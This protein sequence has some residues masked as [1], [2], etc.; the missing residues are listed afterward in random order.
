M[1]AYVSQRVDGPLFAVAIADA[2]SPEVAAAWVNEAARGG[3]YRVIDPHLDDLQGAL[4]I[5][6]KREANAWDGVIRAGT[7]VEIYRAGLN[8]QQRPSGRLDKSD[9]PT[10]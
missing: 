8:W 4:V 7:D 10:Q 2:F 5:A 3:V 1:D 6:M 9:E